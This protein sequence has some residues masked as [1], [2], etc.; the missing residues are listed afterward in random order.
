MRDA[1]ETKTVCVS[2]AGHPA[3]PRLVQHRAELLTRYAVD[4]DEKTARGRLMGKPFSRKLAPFGECVHCK[5]AA[6][7][8]EAAGKLDPRGRDGV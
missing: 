7:N 6:K 5:V 8:G 3:A 2:A 1:V 4:E